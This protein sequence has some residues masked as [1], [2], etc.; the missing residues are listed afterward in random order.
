[1]TCTCGRNCGLL[2]TATGARWHLGGNDEHGKRRPLDDRT[3]RR[4]RKA[5]LFDGCT[6][7]DPVTGTVW[8]RRD[9]LTAWA[10]EAVAS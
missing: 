3:W 9:A 1:M 10:A 6:F 5:G 4:W 2:L 8:Y 7:E